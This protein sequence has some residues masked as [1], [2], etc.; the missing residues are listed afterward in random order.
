MFIFSEKHARYYFTKD[1]ILASFSSVDDLPESTKTVISVLSVVSCSEFD[2]TTLTD[3][4][5]LPM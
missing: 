3:L 2:M 4:H 1:E 5:A